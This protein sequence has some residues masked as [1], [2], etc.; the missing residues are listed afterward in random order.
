MNQQQLIDQIHSEFDTAQ[1]RL[2]EQANKILTSNPEYISSLEEIGERLRRIGFTEAPTAKKSI[3]LKKH[4]TSREAER[5]KTKEE[6]DIIQYYQAQYPFLKFL[7]ESELDRICDKYSLMYAPINHYIKDVPEKNL[8]DI[9]AAQHVRC[10]DS[11]KDQIFIQLTKYRADAKELEK[12]IGKSLIPYE[13]GLDSSNE[14]YNNYL[15]KAIRQMGYTG[16][17]PGWIYLEGKVHK[18]N[19]AG[20]FIAAPESHFNLKGLD[21]KTRHGFFEVFK[22]EIKDP[23]V[24]RYV[25]GGI[26]VITKWGLEANDP[27]LVVPKLN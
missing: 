21:K 23:I 17:M 14:P 2:L 3:E 20:L 8:S 18:Q 22:K 5:V 7:T 24:F 4:R 9:E 12:F 1:E 6:A 13:G 25:R 19:K 11:A 16:F 15:E 26:Q 10:G 27:S